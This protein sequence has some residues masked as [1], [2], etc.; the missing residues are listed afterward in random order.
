MEKYVE[1]LGEL[2]LK[3]AVIANLLRRRRERRR[4][5]KKDADP[6]FPTFGL[7]REYD[8]EDVNV[9]T[10]ALRILNTRSTTTKLNR[11]KLSHKIYMYM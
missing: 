6:W 3:N 5:E 8:D 11:Q 1:G 4:Q 2:K 7:K 9:Y 10:C